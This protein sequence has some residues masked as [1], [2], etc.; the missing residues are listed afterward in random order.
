[1]KNYVIWRNSQFAYH[2]LATTKRYKK[3]L[4]YF[5]NIIIIIFFIKNVQLCKEIF[6]FSNN[7]LTFY[8]LRNSN[9]R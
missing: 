8:E 5:L 6:R 9:L 1:M 4:W 2:Y 7:Q 3:K